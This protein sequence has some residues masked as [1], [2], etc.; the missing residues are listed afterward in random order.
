[1]YG[2]EEEKITLDRESF[3]VLSSDTR[4]GILKSLSVRRKTLSELSKEHKMSVSTIS[5]HLDKLVKADL[6]K[7]IDDGHKWKYYELTKKGRAVLNPE[8]KKVWILLS[9]SLIGLAGAGI[10]M[11][12]GAFSRIFLR[13]NQNLASAPKRVFDPNNGFAEILTNNASDLA[14][15]TGE[16]IDKAAPV[17]GTIL[18]N[19]TA[20]L[21]GAAD[22]AAPLAS[23]GADM[24]SSTP[25]ALGIPWLH[26]III[27]IFAVISIYFI[28]RI[29]RRKKK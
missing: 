18:D 25:S 26:A 4:V 1:M 29:A 13:F 23:E 17:A 11:M 9:L 22:N 3:K 20:P 21:S 19:L 16:S 15:G 2:E 7:Q 28:I 5:E 14:A 24:L 27:A 12:T 10:D 8:E 6:I